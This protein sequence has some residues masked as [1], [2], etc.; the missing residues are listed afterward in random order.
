MADEEQHLIEAGQQG[1]VEAFN[2]LVRLYEGRVYNLCYHMLGDSDS[3]ADASQETFLS[4]FRNLRRFRGG[5]FRAWM[6]RI[7]TN[8]CYDILR[9]RK[10]R[11]AI[12]LDAALVA[13]EDSTRAFDPPDQRESPDEFALRRELAA[14]IQAG[15]NCLPEDQRITIIL[16]DI[17]GMSYD[18]IAQTTGTTLGTIKSRVSR[19]RARLRD[20]LKAGE[21]LPTRYRHE[22]EDLGT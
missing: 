13:D 15:L 8:T 17:Q 16:C 7:A 22:G 9:A 19:G 18:E 10:R 6:L 1:D 14:A 2:Q 4:A 5:S 20:L 21:L 11:P 3:A 12:S